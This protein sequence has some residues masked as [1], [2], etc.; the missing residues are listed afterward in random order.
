MPLTFLF[1]LFLSLSRYLE[2]LNSDSLLLDLLNLNQFT[3][4][5]ATMASFHST[6]E[7]RMF[8]GRIV[9]VHRLSYQ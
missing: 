3:T 7:R 4:T 6:L 2:Y 9:E 5:G 8:A 1:S